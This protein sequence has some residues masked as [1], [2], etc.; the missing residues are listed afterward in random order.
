MSQLKLRTK[1]SNVNGQ[2]VRQFRAVSTGDKIV[3]VLSYPTFLY[4]SNDE[5]TGPFTQK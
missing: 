3:R 1:C 2:D 5:D 4:N